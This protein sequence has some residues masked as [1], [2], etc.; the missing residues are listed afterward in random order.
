MKISRI[1]DLLEQNTEKY[2]SDTIVLAGKNKGKWET[3]TS[4]EYH[5]NVDALSKGLLSMGVKKDDKIATIIYNCP[6]WNFFDMALM[7]IGAIQVPIYPTISE[8]N[9]DYILKEAEVKLIIVS[10]SEVF[11]RIKNIVP[12]IPS[13]MDVYSIQE[14]EGLKHWKEIQEKGKVSFTGDLSSIRDGI[15]T[16]DV[17]TII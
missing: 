16:H 14:T 7:Q 8:A 1:F 5:E 2:A 11:E 3:Y 15:D 10:D 17:A 13:L 9:Y 4:A 12:N 6:E